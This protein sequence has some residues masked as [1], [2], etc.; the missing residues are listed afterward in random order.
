MLQP[1]KRKQLDSNIRKMLDNGASQEDVIAYSKDFTSQ[2]SEKKNEISDSTSQNQGLDSGQETVNGS[3]ATQKD[4][5]T[6]S[7]SYGD[8]IDE[9]KNSPIENLLPKKEPEKEEESYL[10]NLYRQLKTGS[11]DLGAMMASIPETVY[12]VFALPQ[13]LVSKATG[14]ET[15]TSADEFKKD[16]GL[17]N[18]VL[19]FYN[20]EV[21]KLESETEEYNKKYDKTGIFE[22]LKEGNWSDAFELLGSGITRSTPVSLSMMIGGASTSAAKLSAGATPFFVE[23]QAQQLREENPEMDEA[24]VMIKALGMA[25]AETVFSS[26]G[27]GTIGKVYKD[28]LLKEGSEKGAQ[29]FKNGL[30]QAYETA[31]KKYGL[32][33]SATGEGIEEVATQITQNMI[34]GKDPFENVADAF[35]QGVGGGVLYGAP[36]TA[37]NVKNIINEGVARSDIKK[38]INNSDFNDVTEVFL[39][40]INETAINLS[41]KD[42]NKNVLEKEVGKKVSEGT[43]TEKEGKN[44]I[45]N[46]NKAKLV[47]SEIE[48]LDLTSDKKQKAAELLLEKRNIES[49]IEGKDKFLFAKESQRISDI[50]NELSNLREGDNVLPKDREIELKDKA[51]REL[52]K[53]AGEQDI[54]LNDA[55]IT[56][57]ALEIYKREQGETETTVQEQEA[58]PETQEQE[59]VAE[60]SSQKELINKNRQD[61]LEAISKETENM[62]DDEIES[63]AEDR[64]KRRV[65]VNERFDSELAT[66][67]Q[68]TNETTPTTD[69]ESD[70][71]VRPIVEPSTEQKQATD[72]QSAIDF[73]SSERTSKI[74]TKKV[75]SKSGS[76]YDVD[77]DESGNVTEIRNPK[78]KTTI[79]KFVEKQTK[80]GKKLSKNPKYSEV[81]SVALGVITEG[82][83]A[84]EN[85]QNFENALNAIEPTDAYSYARDYL[86][87][88]GGISLE[89]AKKET[90][91]S[92]K[93][94]RWASKTNKGF[95]KDSE[96]PS[97]ENISEKAPEGIDQQDVRDALI[98]ILTSKSSKTQLQDE[99][100][101][102]YNQ[103]NEAQQEEQARAFLSTLT[104]AEIAMYES[105]TAEE[106][107]LSELTDNEKLEYYENEYK[108]QQIDEKPNI[109]PISDE[110]SKRE[111]IRDIDIKEKGGLEKAISFLESLE[112]DLD[113][114][115]KETLGMNMPVVVAKGAISVMKTSLKTAN[116]IADAIKD[117]IDYIKTTDWY[118]SLS[119]SDKNDV[120]SFFETNVLKVPK[121]ENKDDISAFE[122]LAINMPNTGEVKHY[123]SGETIEKYTS[124]SPEN[125]QNYLT[126]RLKEALMHG[127]DIIDA[128]KKA[129]GDNYVSKTLEF[130]DNSPISPD[131][132]GLIYISLEN[133]LVKQKITNPDNKL[134]IQKQINLIRVKRQAYARANSIALN[135]NRL[136]KFAEFGY[137]ISEITDEMFS[138]KERKARNKIEKAMQSSMDNINKE[139]ESFEQENEDNEYGFVVSPPK[140][141]RTASVVKK[142]LSNVWKSMREDLIK[143]TRDGTLNVS[144]PYAKQLI[145]ATPHIVKA[146][147]LM[148]ELGGL[149]AK[150][151]VDEIHAQIKKTF[152]SITKKD[153]GRIIS[154]NESKL[155]PNTNLDNQQK[156]KQEL[157]ESGLGR[158]I[159]VTKKSTNSEGKIERVKE[160]RQV[161]DWKK[162]AGEEGSVENIR[163]RVEE[164]LKNKGYSVNEI[165]DFSESLEDEYHNLRASIIEKSYNELQTR[166][167]PIGF[168]DRRT[169]SRRLAEMYNFGVFDE[170]TD[171]YNNIMNSILGLN[172]FE[173]N[174]FKQLQEKGKVLADLYASKYEEMSIKTEIDKVQKQINDILYQYNFKTGG[175]MFKLAS[176][177]KEYMDFSTRLILHSVG[178]IVQNPVSGAVQLA[179]LKASNLFNG[180]GTLALSK[181]RNII[182]L[183]VLNDIIINAGQTYG[184]VESSLVGHG[185]TE[186]RLNSASKNKL[187]NGFIS[188]AIGR[189]HLEAPDSFFKVILTK[190]KF[191]QNIIRILTSK[192][193]PNGAMSKKEAV[194][195]VS[196][197]LTGQS[198]EDAKVKAKNLIDTINEKNKGTKNKPLSDNKESIIRLADAIVNESL[199]LGGKLTQQQI[200]AS[201]K[202]AYTSAG[203]DIGHEA[204]NW[205]S[206]QVKLM[207]R[208]IDKELKQAVKEKN[209]ALASLLTV[210]KS[211]YGNVISTFVGGGTNWVVITAQNAGIDVISP[212]FDNIMA[213]TAKIDLNS[214]EGVKNL[215]KAL[216]RKSNARS[217]NSRLL[218]GGL[219]QLVLAF[220]VMGMTDDGDDLEEYFKKNPWAKKYFPYIAPTT[221]MVWLAVE[222]KSKDFE[223]EIRAV[224][225]V[226]S[227]YFDNSTKL[228]SAVSDLHKGY[229][230]EYGGEKNIEKGYGKI[231]SVLGSKAQAPLPWRTVRDIQ[232]IY[233]GLEG[234]PPIKVNY[235]TNGF[236]D[237]YFSG[238]FIDF[239]NMKPTKENT[240]TSNDYDKYFK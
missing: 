217:T 232:N 85:K 113:A 6:P 65:D 31:L 128:S 41:Q 181:Q 82:Q 144:V 184:N 10:S 195:Y 96:L 238:G 94:V 131:K 208:K 67:E 120:P 206:S 147:K 153:I 155:K 205:I 14:L 179:I 100:I 38:Q 226:R 78:T 163:K 191:E 61:A 97:I 66:L 212:I 240:T 135:M 45:E 133:D 213:K 159:T 9:L 148:V 89:S 172:D 223:K 210:S 177:T 102:E 166:N 182:A 225:G 73:E 136:Q 79:S 98:D 35:L 237:G 228:I 47:S 176:L 116:S 86:V 236:W 199:L 160:K 121:K 20:E 134:T 3:S 84:K 239:I 107:Y 198:F 24:T 52:V 180:K 72:V 68:Q 127:V 51:S 2:F 183:N 139:A 194:R 49:K 91:L 162:L 125:N 190:K 101:Q 157:I 211:I 203:F 204:N 5:Q 108:K 122:K 40:P 63:T 123:L 111:Q 109:E 71:N 70:G 104:D 197:M 132:K 46:F 7:Y 235:T 231:G 151:I 119:E 201:Y 48:G 218:I 137:N 21:K 234:L 220:A 154:E 175:D 37:K 112:N 202:A 60:V 92:T 152:P 53:E 69:T 55:Q 221:L 1:D 110:K 90:R 129:F 17:K 34:S 27:T 15:G 117:A 74:T 227:P 43:I 88:G 11:S 233:R 50:N 16:Y 145:V 118:K 25:G 36:I 141:R 59:E 214:E 28:I 12:N 222:G 173:K 44:I 193:N 26:I 143:S 224:S 57:R 189:L 158:E 229:K 171:T 18:N 161:L 81:E 83:S 142:E 146:T 58:Q 209:Y 126:I 39:S 33:T 192:T 188:A 13:N 30:I 168:I 76:N 215:E 19:D 219:S 8:R 216:L 187:Y 99:L 140:N 64:I 106:N 167:K 174:V 105:V 164:N 178:Q 80:N 114:F 22:N 185:R 95:V 207:S 196:D 29:I 103:V 4:K 150:Q 130:L 169:D 56:E 42:I 138:P 115:G 156:L 87:R 165:K 54:T 230:A 32:V 186:D 77:F 170:D 62:T 93:E 124:E 23:G 149:T 75:K 200:E